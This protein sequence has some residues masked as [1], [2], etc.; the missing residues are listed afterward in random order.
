MRQFTFSQA[1]STV[2]LPLLL[3]SYEIRLCCAATTLQTEFNKLSTPCQK[4]LKSYAT[5]GD[6]VI[7]E[8]S[9]IG[10]SA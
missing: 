8:C 7:G 10:V 9:G 4:V 2:L 6:S 1:T 5:T 3:L